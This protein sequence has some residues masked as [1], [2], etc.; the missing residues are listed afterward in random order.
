MFDFNF[1]NSFKTVNVDMVD[2]VE[3]TE[4][5]ES[6]AAIQT[7]PVVLASQMIIMKYL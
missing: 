2:S 6:Q 1:K 7:I 5:T 3:V 4:Q